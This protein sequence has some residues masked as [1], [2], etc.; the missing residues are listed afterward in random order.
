MVER[1]KMADRNTVGSTHFCHKDAGTG[2]HLG[3]LIFLY[4][5]YLLADRRHLEGA[6]KHIFPLTVP[7]SLSG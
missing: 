6:F 7:A 4:I 5:S 1:L 2:T 3:T